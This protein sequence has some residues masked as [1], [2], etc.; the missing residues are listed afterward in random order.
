MKTI[1][2]ISLFVMIFTAFFITACNSGSNS[3]IE[4]SEDML[5]T[6]SVD[7]QTP[8]E[9]VE[10]NNFFILIKKSGCK[11][12]DG[13]TNSEK[14]TYETQTAREINL[15][16]YFSDVAYF[17]TFEKSQPSL[18]YFSKVKNMSDQMGLSTAISKDTYN[19]LE[20]NISNAD[21]LLIITDNSYKSVIQ[22]LI[23]T[24]NGKSLAFIM[25]G[26]W[27]E[28]MYV[29]VNIV[30]KY[31]DNDA[32]INEIASQKVTFDNLF[33]N[34]KKYKEDSDVNE[35]LVN[36]KKIKTIYKQLKKETVEQNSPANKDTSKAITEQKTKYIFTKELYE[37]F[38]KEINDLRTIIIKMS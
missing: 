30:G 27:V 13:L 14:A 20:K 24:G 29:A 28:S 38:C 33:R 35:Q 26:G 31:S 17:A 19:D 12:S 25:L 18:K 6:D 9:I 32:N 22:K 23:E 10:P 5:E 7:E 36:I 15:G 21:S 4:D 37:S 1:K 2:Y 34:L 11:F 8:V 16:V 3:S